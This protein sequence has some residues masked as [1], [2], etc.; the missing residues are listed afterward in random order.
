MQSPKSIAEQV[1]ELRT[2]MSGLGLAE[3]G[4][5][6][7]EAVTGSEW[8][9]SGLQ[10]S[11]DAVQS[12]RA[13]VLFAESLDRISRDQEHT[14]R[15]YKLVKY[16]GGRIVTLQEGEITP[17]HVGLVGTF[18]QMYLDNLAF[19]TRR[20]LRGVVE[21]GRVASRPAYGYE[22]TDVV[23]VLRIVV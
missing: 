7:D 22:R 6:S 21:D 17:L 11:L 1:R 18:S 20:G 5:F 14:A 8:M 3:A 12:G 2:A 13:D 4:S 9:R 10:A 19:K 23:G 16:W 15:V